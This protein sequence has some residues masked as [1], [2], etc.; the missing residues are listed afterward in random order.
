MLYTGGGVTERDSGKKRERKN[1][2]E[3]ETK[4]Q[5]FTASR[6]VDKSVHK[7]HNILSCGVLFKSNTFG[8]YSFHKFA[9]N[10]NKENLSNS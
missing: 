2:K 8:C 6:N 3:R 7:E 4:K 9:F 10:C 5:E 1:K